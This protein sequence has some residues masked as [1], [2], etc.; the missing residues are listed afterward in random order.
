[1]AV[2]GSL[3][4]L[5]HGCRNGAEGSFSDQ[6]AAAG[7]TWGQAVILQ[8]SDYSH[9]YVLFE[10]IYDPNAGAYSGSGVANSFGASIAMW[11]PEPVVVVRAPYEDVGNAS[12]AGAVYIYSPL[13]TPINP[14]VP[15]PNPPWL[16]SSSITGAGSSA[17]GGATND[18]TPT[19]DGTATPGITVK[20]YT[21]GEFLGSAVADTTGGS[22]SITAHRQGT[23][24]LPNGTYTSY[25]VAVDS[26]GNVSYP[27]ACPTITV[28]TSFPSSWTPQ[29]TSLRSTYSIY[30]SSVTVAFPASA[31]LHTVSNGVGQYNFSLAKYDYGVGD[32]VT[33]TT[34]NPSVNGPNNNAWTL[35][36]GLPTTA[37]Q[38]RLAYTARGHRRRE[39]P[40]PRRE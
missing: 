33:D 37:G 28:Q 21:A 31:Q 15:P 12:A 5:G 23:N 29:F 4:A 10:H 1:M 8:R 2:S 25:V 16:D 39:S 36:N 38:Y 22:Y 30:P 9:S 18:D 24:P 3:V 17:A 19:F 6:P 35:Y 32:Y 20:L 13:S 27:T 40:G 11:G 34:F 14:S 26:N 7:T